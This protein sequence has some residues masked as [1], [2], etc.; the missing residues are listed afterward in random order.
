MPLIDIKNYPKP[1]IE[2]LKAALARNDEWSAAAAQSAKDA[3]VEYLIEVQGS[4]CAYCKRL[5]KNEIG[6]REL[7]HIL[8]KGALGKSAIR[9]VSNAQKDRRVTTGY[10][11]F[12]F[13]PANLILTCKRCN[14]RKGS[15]DCRKDRS[16]VAPAAYPSAA[17]DFEWIHPAYH[18]FDQHIVLLNEFAYQEVPGSNGAA[19]IDACKLAGIEALEARARDLRLKEIKNVNMLVLDL[20]REALPDNDIVDSVMLLFPKVTE[21]MIRKLVRGFRDNIIP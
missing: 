17:A 2:K 16:T 19:V 15:Y 7:D 14:H 13:E 10:P 18:D 12:R 8:P 21:L 20:L 5:I 6:L 11:A 9:A 4:R 1:L 3:L